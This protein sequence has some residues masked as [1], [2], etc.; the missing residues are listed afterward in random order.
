MDFWIPMLLA[1]FR[2]IGPRKLANPCRA[3]IVVC[4]SDQNCRVIGA[5]QLQGFL[6]FI[7]E[8]DLVVH[9]EPVWAG[10]RETDVLVLQRSQVKDTGVAL[11]VQQYELMKIFKTWQSLGEVQQV[12]LVDGQ[13]TE[14]RT[15][16]HP[17][18][19]LDLLCLH[20]HLSFLQLFP[21]LKVPQLELCIRLSG[22]PN[23]E[24]VPNAEMHVITVS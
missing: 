7:T 6:L 20:S 11:V 10:D 8:I 23:A 4:N 3:G 14:S 1:V 9:A 18:L 24:G 22:I 5:V 13:S 17:V 16:F 15:D 21:G 2:M 19:V 12:L